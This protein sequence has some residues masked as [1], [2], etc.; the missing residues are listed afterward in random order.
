[1][2]Q[3]CSTNSCS[4]SLFHIQQG[5]R[6][7]Y[8]WGSIKKGVSSDKSPVPEITHTEERPGCLR[9]SSKAQRPRA[10][11]GSLHLQVPGEV[12]TLNHTQALL[13]PGIFLL[14]FSVMLERS[15]ELI[16]WLLSYLLVGLCYPHVVQTENYDK[17]KRPLKLPDP[18]QLDVQF[19]LGFQEICFGIE[20]YFSM[21]RGERKQQ[22][23]RF[24]LA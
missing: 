24:C 7:A 14:F 8:I 15:K 22:K 5:W 6:R 20:T 2:P 19:S 3:I 18:Y 16:Q 11:A 21:S 10:D 13:S 4:L 23:F 17:K 9:S 1:M 12:L